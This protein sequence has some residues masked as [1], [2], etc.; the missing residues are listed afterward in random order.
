MPPKEHLGI[1]LNTLYS[2]KS[3]HEGA[4]GGSVALLQPCKAWASESKVVRVAQSLARHGPA[5]F[6]KCVARSLQSGREQEMY[7]N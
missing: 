3:T 5:T 1:S 7:L 4:L 6:L 2:G